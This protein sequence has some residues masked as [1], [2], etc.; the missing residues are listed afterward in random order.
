M[1]KITPLQVVVDR[2]I[3][4]IEAN[5]V[6]PWSNGWVGNNTPVSITG[7][8]YN[9][10]NAMWLAFLTK[11]HNYQS[12]VWVTQAALKREGGW[13]AKGEKFVP[14]LYPVTVKEECEDGQ[15]ID[16]FRGWGYHNVCN[17]SQVANMGKLQP[18]KVTKQDVAL[19]PTL[20]NDLIVKHGIKI[21]DGRPLY[22]T[23]TGEITVPPVGSCNSVNDYWSNVAHEIG[24]WTRGQLGHDA[25]IVKKSYGYEELVAELFAVQL[26][27]MAGIAVEID[28][29]AGYLQGWLQSLTNDPTMLHKAAKEAESAVAW[30]IG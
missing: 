2:V 4:A 6:L 12:N 28:N 5:Q 17:L 11:A 7:R 18:P 9:G 20:I 27:G 14:V 8:P 30:I 10:F 26:C 21:T 24:H 13:I 19:K 25:P 15:I 29:S 1:D 3:A 23:T 16:R 22:N